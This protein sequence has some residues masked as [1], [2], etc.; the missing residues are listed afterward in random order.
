MK[1]R[2]DDGQIGGMEGPVFGVLIFVF[3]TLVIANAWGV[4]DAK[5][6]AASAAREATRTFVESRAGDTA[7]ALDEA[8]AA[9][10]ATITGYGRD[11][12]RMSLVAE[13]AVLQRCARATFRV[14]YAVPLITIPVLGRYGR[15]FT[16][17]ARHSEI[18]DPF[19]SGLGDT[20]ACGATVG[21]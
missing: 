21:S 5:L 17:S 19:R 8:A 10:S 15:G 16:A 4:I 13:S 6:A 20:S 7:A 9:A 2:G 12:A 3:G 11:P 18:V 14:D 1:A